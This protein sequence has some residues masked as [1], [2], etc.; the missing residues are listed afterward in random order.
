MNKYLN[1][2]LIFS[3]LGCH[4]HEKHNLLKNIRSDSRAFNENQIDKTIRQLIHS[5]RSD[6]A[7]KLLDTLILYNKQSGFLYFERGFVDGYNFRPEAAIK[8]FKIAESLHY[9]KEECRRMIKFTQIAID[10]RQKVINERIK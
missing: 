3:F 7:L 1:I 4:K 10:E 8:E 9:D 6:Q 2:F 5:N